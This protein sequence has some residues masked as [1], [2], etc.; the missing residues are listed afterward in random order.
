MYYISPNS[1]FWD[2]HNTEIPSN[3]HA[4]LVLNQIELLP[5]LQIRYHFRLSAGTTFWGGDDRFSIGYDA[6]TEE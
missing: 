4:N 6:S 3:S 1:I 5:N 2:I